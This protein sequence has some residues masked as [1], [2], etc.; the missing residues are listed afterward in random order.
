MPAGACWC[1]GQGGHAAARCD[2]GSAAGAGLCCCSGAGG[3]GSTAVKHRHAHEP[4]GA[5]GG[6]GV[7][8]TAQGQAAC[9]SHLL[10][11]SL[12]KLEW[13]IDVNDESCSAK[14]SAMPYTPVHGVGKMCSTPAT[15]AYNIGNSADNAGNG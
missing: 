12:L 5:G 8:L 7:S 11:T 15:C 10:A 14:H 3:T 13:S 6:L 9:S 1:C 4:V 2:D